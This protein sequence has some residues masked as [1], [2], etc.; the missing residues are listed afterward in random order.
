MRVLFF[1]AKLA[2]TTWHNG[3]NMTTEP[4]ANSSDNKLLR[5]IISVVRPGQW[6]K[7]AFVA[8]P[9]LFSRE[10]RD[11]SQ[12]MASLRAV[13]CFCAVSSMVYVFNDWCDRE[14]DRQHPL[15]KDR[16]IAAGILNS[17]WV[18]GLIGVTFGIGFGLAGTLGRGF[19]L[20][21]AIYI[22]IH[23]AYS[24][25]L[26]RVAI[27]D[28]LTIAAGF[29]LRVWGGGLAIDVHPSHWLILCTLMLSVFL[30]FC[31]RRAELVDMGEHAGSRSVLKDYSTA[32][33]DQAVSMMTSVTI[34]CYV[35]YVIDIYTIETFHTRGLLVTV[36]FVMY[37]LFRYLQ[38]VYHHRRGQDPAFLATRDWPLLITL[39]LWGLICLLVIQYPNFIGNMFK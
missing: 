32:F 26:K 37:G 10:F 17:G 33:L 9:L 6:L 30:G 27:V 19:V 24:L 22:I 23:L 25:Y 15:K 8:A 38:L 14:E 4:Q 3:V 21:L 29:V 28:V 31:K 1:Y 12:I 18:I 11:F 36:P 20:V 34:V 5:A 35:L 13:I 7:N 2:V 16:P 39:V